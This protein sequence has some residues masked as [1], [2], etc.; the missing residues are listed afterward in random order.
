MDKNKYSLIANKYLKIFN[1]IGENKLDKIISLL[2]LTPES[3]VA[4]EDY[5]KSRKMRVEFLRV[6]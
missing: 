6:F 5:E 1:P 4:D 3:R 2:N